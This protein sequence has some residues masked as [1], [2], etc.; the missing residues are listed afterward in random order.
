MG[1]VPGAPGPHNR[2]IPDHPGEQRP[3]LAPGGCDLDIHF[4]SVLPAAVG[5]FTVPDDTRHTGAMR[6]LIATWEVCCA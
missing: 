2:N 5:E 6:Q 4:S 1:T 3:L